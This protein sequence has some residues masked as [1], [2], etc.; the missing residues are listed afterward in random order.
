MYVGGIPI[1]VYSP[2]TGSYSNIDIPYDVSNIALRNALRRIIGFE[3][4]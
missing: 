2:G 4:V 1:A 3:R